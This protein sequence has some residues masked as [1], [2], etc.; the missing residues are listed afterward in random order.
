MHSYSATFSAWKSAYSGMLP[1]EKNQP[2]RD[3]RTAHRFFFE[4]SSFLLNRPEPAVH[5]LRE[6]FSAR[7]EHNATHSDFAE[8]VSAFEAT[9][10]IMSR[11]EGSDDEGIT[12][13]RKD[14]SCWLRAGLCAFCE[15]AILAP[16]FFMVESARDLVSIKS[17]MTVYSIKCS[18][19]LAWLASQ[20]RI[21]I[22]HYHLRN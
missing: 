15:E 9:F 18:N 6:L 11:S 8:A 21:D 4:Y 13:L 7:C 14:W 12:R 20:S 3:A 16:D 5:Y 2:S 10:W 17:V 1:I 22:G 19:N